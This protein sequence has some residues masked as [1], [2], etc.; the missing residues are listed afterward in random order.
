MNMDINSLGW[1]IELSQ[2]AVVGVDLWQHRRIGLMC[3][4]GRAACIMDA[5]ELLWAEDHRNE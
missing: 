3:W 5:A 4:T 1:W 2:C